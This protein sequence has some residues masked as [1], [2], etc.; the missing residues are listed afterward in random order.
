MW[1]A[2]VNWNQPVAIDAFNWNELYGRV[3]INLRGKY[4]LYFAELY[5]GNYSFLNEREKVKLRLKK[6][7]AKFFGWLKIIERLIAVIW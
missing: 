4:V 1:F 3:S 6:I 5:F 2:F 7:C